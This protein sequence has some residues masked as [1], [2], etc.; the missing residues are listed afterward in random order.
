VDDLKLSAKKKDQAL[1]AVKAHE[2]NIRKLMDQAHA[3]LLKKMKEILSEEEFK[4]FQAALDRPRAST[5]IRLGP[6]D[7]PGTGDVQ[8]RIEQL[9]K[10]LDNLRREL[11]H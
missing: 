8:R 5:V 6:A 11:R 9:Q 4:D 3:D 2:K 10:E 7:G 1:A